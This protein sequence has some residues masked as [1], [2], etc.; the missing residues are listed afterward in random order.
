MSIAKDKP[1]SNEFPDGLRVL[2]VDDDSTCLQILAKMLQACRYQVTKCMRAKDALFILRENRGM[3]DIVISDVH[4]PDMDGFRL[5]EIIRL[6]MDLPVVMISSDDGKDVVMEN[7]ING[8]CDYLVKP[9]RMEAIRFIWQHVVRKQKDSLKL[10]AQSKNVEPGKLLQRQSIEEDHASSGIKEKCG[11]SNSRKDEELEEKDRDEIVSLKKPRMVWT[12]ELHQQFVAA[13]NQIGLK[14]AVPKKILE[15]MD[16]SGLT[17][18]NVASHL[19]KYRLYIQRSNV[20]LQYQSKSGNSPVSSRELN[21]K[22]V[23]S[24][25]SCN[26]Q[27]HITS[28]QLSFQSLTVLQTELDQRSSAIL[29]NDMSLVDQSN[30]CNFGNSESRFGTGQQPSYCNK[31]VNLP[32]EVR[33]MIESEQLM[34][35]N[36]QPI[37]I[38][39]NVDLRISD[40]TPDILNLPSLQTSSIANGIYGNPTG[41]SM[42]QMTQTPLTMQR[43]N[44]IASD[45]AFNDGAT[46]YPVSLPSMII[47]FSEGHATKLFEHDFSL[48][49]TTDASLSGN[50]NFEY[51][52]NSSFEPTLFAECFEQDDFDIRPFD[53]QCVGPVEAKPKFNGYPANNQS[54]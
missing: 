52:L 1:I 36:Q 50:R 37:K 24:L 7:I 19:Q 29:Q 21:L 31:R 49:S 27:G 35:L 23:S 18:E 53:E 12:P 30:F 44:G 45:Q 47:N 46:Y 48:E 20:N 33:T 38:F 16:V 34:P 32:H 13:V 41:S 10:L 4:M 43:L 17:R 9:V 8:A 51:N 15:L 25:D 14:N 5:L 22:L 3:F 28:S 2:V 40:G 39:G 54:I 11:S 42:L 6:E 26:L